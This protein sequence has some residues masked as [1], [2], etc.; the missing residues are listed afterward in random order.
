MLNKYTQIEAKVEFNQIW[1]RLG[2]VKEINGNRNLADIQSDRFTDSED[3][4]EEALK[5]KKNIFLYTEEKN[6]NLK[7]CYC[8]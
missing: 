2:S 4:L 7:K 8:K 1:F 5:Q 6:Y 3:D